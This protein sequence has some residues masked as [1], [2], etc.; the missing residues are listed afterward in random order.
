MGE[1]VAS[2]E[3]LERHTLGEVATSDAALDRLDFEPGP[4]RGGDG[5]GYLAAEVKAELDR[6]KRALTRWEQ[7]FGEAEIPMAPIADVGAALDQVEAM[8]YDKEQKGLD[9]TRCI[10]G[11]GSVIGCRDTFNRAQPQYPILPAAIG[12]Q[13]PA[14]PAE[15]IE[16]VQRHVILKLCGGKVGLLAARFRIY[17]RHGVLDG[18][19]RAA[20]N[21]GNFVLELHDVIAPAAVFKAFMD[22]YGDVTKA[23]DNHL[24]LSVLGHVGHLKLRHCVVTISGAAYTAGDMAHTDQLALMGTE[25]A[26]ALR[27]ILA[28]AEPTEPLRNFFHKDA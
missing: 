23:V 2:S 8:L 4:N 12:V 25:T 17:G 7:L 9:P 3:Y 26:G 24:E 10:C 18:R 28:A 14:R 1:V 16:P 13:G 19:P 6:W 22:Q 5:H 11:C 15:A 21:I 20:G 27:E